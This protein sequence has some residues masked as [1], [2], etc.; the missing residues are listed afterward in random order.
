MARQHGRQWV[1]WLRWCLLAMLASWLVIAGYMMFV[2]PS[3]G[4]LKTLRMQT[5]LRVLTHDHQLI[6]LYGEKKRMPVALASVPP[7]LIHA[8]LDTEDQRFYAHAG[9]DFMGLGR[10]AIKLLATGRKTE[11]ASTIT[12]QVARHF[13]L[14]REKT[15]ARKFN[16]ILLALKISQSLSKDQVLWLYLNQIYFGHRAYGVA[17][18]AQVYYGKSLS[19][20]SLPQMAMLAGLPQA[21]SRENPISSPDLAI[22]RR[23]HVLGRMLA[24]GHITAAAYQRAVHAPIT[25]KRHVMRP[26]VS[27]PHVGEMVREAMVK[28]YGPS[29]YTRGLVVVTTLDARLQRAAQQSLRHTLQRYDRARGYRGPL[30]H[31]SVDGAYIDLDA[32]A[33]RLRQWP[34]RD[35][36]QAAWVSQ[37][38]DREAVVLLGDGQTTRLPWSALAWARPVRDAPTGGPLPEHAS[39]ILQL[40]DVVLVARDASGWHLAQLPQVEGA[41]V[42]MSSD[43]GA[44]LAL[45]GGYDFTASAFNR[46]TQAKRQSGS[47]FKPFVYAAALAK[48]YHLA[49]VFDDAPVVTS[50]GEDQSWRPQNHELR[51]YGPTRM[52]EGLVR[53]RNLL[54]IRLLQAAG[55]DFAVD[56]M[57]HFGFSS[58]ALPRHLSLAL[59]T[60]VVTPWDLNQAYGVIASGGYAVTPHVIDAIEDA[61]GQLL[62]RNPAPSVCDSDCLP[63]Q[64]DSLERQAL[65]VP[66]EAKASPAMAPRVVDAAIAYLMDSVLQDVIS[67]GT[68]RRAKVL[69]RSDLAGKTGTTYTDAWFAG[70]GGGVVSTVWVGHDRDL[71]LYRYASQLAL[72][73]WIDYMRVALA[74]RPLRVMAQPESIVSVRI[75][76]K[77]GALAQAGT[78]GIF[79]LFRRSQLPEATALA[80]S[81]AGEQPPIF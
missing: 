40:G 4:T 10:A 15:Y 59:G 72:P 54:T 78:P 74:D 37:V 57:R 76:P 65:A 2:L 18:A 47:S 62:W 42:S 75:D 67:R 5:P 34:V 33:Q 69:H 17:A 63:L 66:G 46:V 79:E 68:G 71:P 29:A 25:A 21:P 80:A 39:D 36:Y 26:A 53:S 28:R 58:D 9:V 11:G 14:S 6:A 35:G 77:S 52:R 8:V 61:G 51:F 7:L 20:L 3:V 38:A 56:Y 23:N 48:G 31:W 24:A 13:F 41:L 30:A 44:V 60:G 22:K 64:V 50:L 19:A 81:Q 32:I 1:K 43:T 70:Y 27:A 49:S 73:V 12:M 45:V 16:E 55:L